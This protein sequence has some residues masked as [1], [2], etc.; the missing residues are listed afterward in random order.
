V[1]IK[2]LEAS[3]AVVNKGVAMS[4]KAPK[5]YRS[6]PIERLRDSYM[7]ACFIGVGV[8]V[9][10][11]LGLLVFGSPGFGMFAGSVAGVLILIGG[12]GWM[13]TAVLI[14][15]RTSSPSEKKK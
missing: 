6:T 10:A 12:P 1:S 14:A 7:T 5:P 15:Y 3:A 9:L 11:L 4:E 2:R 8:F 13:L